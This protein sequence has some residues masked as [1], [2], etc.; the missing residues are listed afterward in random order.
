M[1]IDEL[2]AVLWSRDK[3]VHSHRALLCLTRLTTMLVPRDIESLPRPSILVAA[4]E[5]NLSLCC[6]KSICFFHVV[7]TSCALHYIFLDVHASASFT[8][9]IHSSKGVRSFSR[10]DPRCGPFETLSCFSL[11]YFFKPTSSSQCRS[12]AGLQN[13]SCSAPTRAIQ[14]QHVKALPN[15]DALVDVPLMQNP[16]RTMG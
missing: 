7:N 10:D 15:P 8:T 16:P 12:K 11:F 3:E 2:W 9:V 4:Y 5:S 14:Q 1:L 6:W 13:R